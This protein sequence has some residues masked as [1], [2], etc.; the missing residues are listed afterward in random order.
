[1]VVDMV[2]PSKEETLMEAYEKWRKWADEK[3][4]G[5]IIL[6]RRGQ[7]IYAVE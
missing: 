1:M 3:V 7:N 2:V 6:I 4:R 5:K